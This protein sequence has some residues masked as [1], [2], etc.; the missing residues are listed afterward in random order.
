MASASSR[1]PQWQHRNSVYREVVEKQVLINCS[2][3]IE[4]ISYSL[5]YQ[6]SAACNAMNQHHSYYVHIYL[7]MHIDNCHTVHTCIHN[8]AIARTITWIKINGIHW[9]QT[10]YNWTI[11]QIARKKRIPNYNL[12]SDQ[13]KKKNY[14]L[15]ILFFASINQLNNKII[16]AQK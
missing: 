13:K 6:I 10:R 14:R 9:F 1:E 3:V 12:I 8:N 7:V 15:K 4:S 16:A 2:K 11:A 5:S